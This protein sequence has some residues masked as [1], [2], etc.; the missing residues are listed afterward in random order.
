MKNLK[1]LLLAFLA[2]VGISSCMKDNDY[3]QPDFEAEERRIDS[4]LKAQDT[5]LRNY[6][7][8]NFDNPIEDTTFGIWYEIL[9]VSNDTTFE[10]VAH[11]NSWIP[12]IANVKYTGQLLDGTVFDEQTDKP[13][14]FVINGASGASSGVIYAW[15]L[16]FY[17]QSTNANS[18]SGLTKDGL[19]KGSKIRFVAPSPYCYD[20]QTNEDIPADSPLDFTI[21]VTDIKSSQ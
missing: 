3:E 15:M 1:L 5:I 21:E 19:K 13:T 12:V 9:E 8:E 20:N 4:T 6:A 11:E 10:Y 16:A 17:P 2:V 14:Q 18:F 7:L